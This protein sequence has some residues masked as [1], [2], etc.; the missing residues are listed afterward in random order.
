MGAV[1]V[2]GLLGVVVLLL[3]VLQVLVV[4]AVLQVPVLRA[5]LRV[6][7]VQA[8]LQVYV[9]AVSM[10]LLLLP[11]LVALGVIR[12]RTPCRSRRSQ[13]CL[14]SLAWTLGEFRVWKLV[15]AVKLEFALAT[16]VPTGTSTRSQ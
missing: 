14:G 15:L 4:Q 13:D 9:L 16:A 6:P 1:G 11:T 8:G 5:V 3:A 10:Q 7:V 2:L 12:R